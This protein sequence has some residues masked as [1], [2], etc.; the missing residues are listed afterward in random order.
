MQCLQAGPK[1]PAAGALRGPL[2]LASALLLL[3]AFAVSS[4]AQDLRGRVQGVVTDTSGA[5]I[6]AANV[7]LR[8]VNT[9]V[10]V[11]RQTNEAGRYIFDFVL[12]G[13]YEIRVEVEGFRSYLQ[14]NIL[15]QTRADITVNAAME[16]G[17]IAETVTVEETPVAVQ[18]NSTTMEMTLDTK[19][20]NELPIIHRNPFLLAQLDPAVKYR[21][22]AESSPYHHWAASQ[23]DVGGDTAYKNSVL[24]DGVPQL[25]GAKGTYVPA[26]DAV[27]EV[28]VQ[29]NSVDAEYGHS[30]GGVVSVQ[31][32]S[33]TNDY[34]GSAYYFGRNPIVNARPN[35]LS[36]QASI[37][38]RNVWGFTSGNPLVKNKVFNFFAYEGQ[39][40]REP[41]TESE[42]LPTSLERGGD[43]SNSLNSKG[44]L[45]AIYDPFTTI[46]TGSNTS[47]R[48][49]FANNV[50]PSTRLD[51]TALRMMSTLWQPNQPGDNASGANNFRYTYPQTFKY[52]NFSDRADWNVNDS[53][54]VFGRLSRIH[55]VQSDPDFTGG[56]PLQPKAGS[57]RN[58][59]QTSGDVVW[60]INP[61]TVFN[62]RGSW[63]KI[64]DSFAAPSV[65][66]GE[67]GLADL[68]PGNN[69]YASHVAD[70]PAVYHPQLDVRADTRTRL[71][72]YGF[73]YQVPKTYNYDAKLSKQ[74]G[75]HY[76]KI[77]HQYRAQRVE[78]A[79]P[80]GIQFIFQPSDTADTFFAP[81][82]AEVGHAYASLMLGAV[83]D[84]IVQ[85]VPINRGHADVYGFYVQD[86]FKVSQRVTINMGLRYEYETPLRDPQRRLS[87]GPDFSQGLPDLEAAAAP[88]PDEVLALRNRPLTYTGAWVFTSDEQ[89]GYYKAQKTIFLPRLGI[90]Y[91]LDNKTALRIGW[92][93]YAVPPIQDRSSVDPLGS[94]P[95][96]GFTGT[97]RPLSVLQGVPRT[98]LSDPF[99][100][101]GTNSNPLI[102]PR[103]KTAG[104]YSVLGTGEGVFQT[105]NYKQGIND[106][107]NITIQRQLVSRIV[108]DATFFMNY[109]HNHSLDTQVNNADPRI[110]YA[111]QSAT[112]QSVANP[113]YGLPKTIMPG[114]LANSKNIAVG[115]LLRP[116]PYYANVEQL[117]MPVRK[118]RYKSVQLKLQRPFTNGFN[119]TMGYNYS[120]GRNGA[121]WDPVD[122]YD[123][124]PTLQKDPLQ[125]STFTLGGIYELPFGH[126]RQF[127][128]GMP[129]AL[130]LIVGG[131]STSGI[132][133]YVQGEL[134]NFPAQV[135][136]TNDV[137]LDNPTRQ[138]W[139]NTAAFERQPA[140]TRRS[141]PWFVDGVR[142]PRF[143]NLDLTLNK[144]F[145]VTEKLALELRL[146]AY[147]L[148]NSFMGANPSTNIN[149]GGSFGVVNSQLATSSGREF[150]YSA[151]F[152]W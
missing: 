151:R 16:I 44:G 130:D 108:V 65:E 23:L 101:S 124:V 129:K 73:W 121:Y 34:H 112:T 91:R 84:G 126:G 87:I 7:T 48:Q 21:G 38:R 6:P 147:N 98:Q 53:V 2:T 54:K 128:A 66:I 42:T 17:A 9:N 55:T 32:K 29:Q 10:A 67:Q 89:R 127:G 37:V 103:G 72:R 22:G 3:A 56:S 61:T 68:W 143:S 27:S 149:D 113:Y 105:Q 99:P 75:K 109:G 83:N 13:S 118:V 63:S 150:Q 131:W 30:A 50:I 133:R 79:R 86:D 141:N 46:V 144:K 102:V 119:F 152:I 39:N 90:A 8:N 120:R 111:A 24:L 148:T 82:T 95:Y 136:L 64:N 60:T 25:V 20:A 43:F 106:R 132:Y 4:P 96:P 12:P 28:N 139:F 125:G 71:G 114:E 11:D 15:V 94:T 1:S 33:G 18:F 58:T 31:M 41:R 74:M 77:G 19:M 52:Y 93:R 62:I 35:P 59:W 145:P 104:I 135:L 123:Q 80:R 88:M 5:V 45:R 57:A 117:S 115:D 134:L 137:K 40:T 110:A 76:L 92:A 78:A 49:P 122:M 70:I 26:M 81:K 116:Y 51:P 107:F 14:Q 140:F 36:S 69:W 142:G 47:S 138:Q 146:E 85:T 100:S 97:T